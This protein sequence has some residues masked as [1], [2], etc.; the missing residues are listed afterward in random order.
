MPKENPC[1]TLNYKEAQFR[2]RMTCSDRDNQKPSDVRH[3]MQ[4]LVHNLDMEEHILYRFWSA[5]LP[6]NIKTVLAL[7]PKDTTLTRLAEVADQVYDRH[8]V[9]LQI[10]CRIDS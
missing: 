6:R 8:T 1:D 2:Q 9:G 4:E 5:A 3:Q 10:N 7:Q